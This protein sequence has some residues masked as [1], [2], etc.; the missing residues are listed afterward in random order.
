MTS[1]VESQASTPA[2]LAA[3][4]RQHDRDRFATAMFA[5]APRRENLFA[6][7]AFNYELAKVR[8]SVREP[9][10]G[11]VRLQWWRDTLAE[12]AAGQSPR[13]HEVAEPLARVIRAHH[14][15]QS[16]LTRMIDAREQDLLPDPP[17]T[18][19]QLEDYAEA[20]GGGLNYLA[21]QALAVKDGKGAAPIAARHVGVGYALAGVLRA[22]AFN[23][24]FGLS[25]IPI[26]LDPDRHALGGKATPALCDAAATIAEAAHARFAKARSLSDDIPEAVMPVLLPMLVA[27]R[28]LGQIE[29]A[30]YD[31]FAPRILRPD[32]WRGLRLALA[33][34]RGQL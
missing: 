26:E 32:P 15:S 27:E 30:G 10:M 29:R 2:S 13:R 24:R 11:R 8:E 7:Y 25:H 20:T 5:P 31:L 16:T 19:T 22:T 14:L 28:W 21:L 1:V 9:M 4:V 17:T 18:F 12:I 6:L 23:A 33:A 34:R 3:L